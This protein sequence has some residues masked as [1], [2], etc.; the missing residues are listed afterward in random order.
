MSDRELVIRAVKEMPE[1][2]TLLEIVT[3][4]KLLASVQ[5]GLDDTRRGAVTAHEDV[6]KQLE[7]WITKSSGRT[8]A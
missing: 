1:S 8:A 5:E 3:S 4:L 7:T 2:T 6:V